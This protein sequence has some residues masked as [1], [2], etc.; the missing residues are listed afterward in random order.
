MLRDV[1]KYGSPSTSEKQKTRGLQPGHMKGSDRADILSVVR[2]FVISC[3]EKSK[4]LPIKC[5]GRF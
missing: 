1:G 4:V 5:Y 3:D 2:L